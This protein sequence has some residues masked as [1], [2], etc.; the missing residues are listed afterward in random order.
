MSAEILKITALSMQ[1]CVPKD[2]DD[3]QIHEFANDTESL[4][5]SMSWEIR[6]E[7]SVLLNGDPE[8]AQCSSKPDHVHLMLDC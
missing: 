2:W 4:L 1:V 5:G 3:D 6:R 7:G 8:R